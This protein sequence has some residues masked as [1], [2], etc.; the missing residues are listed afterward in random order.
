MRAFGAAFVQRLKV[1]DIVLLHGQ[2]GA[3][4]TTL[5]KGLVES[6]GWNEPVRSPT[7]NLVQTFETEPPILHADLYRL[8]HSDDLGLEEQFQRYI[9]FIEWPERIDSIANLVNVWHITIEYLEAGRRVIVDE[10]EVRVR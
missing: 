1:G 6:L 8:S 4:K 3:G 7:Y 10:P 2:L 5:V 9:S